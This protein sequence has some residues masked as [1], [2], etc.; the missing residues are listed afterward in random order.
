MVLTVV[1]IREI[2][3]YACFSPDD[4]E[5]ANE[6]YCVF[7]LKKKISYSVPTMVGKTPAPRPA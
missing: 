5:E 7:G 3:P 6:I 1:Y 4:G 2:V